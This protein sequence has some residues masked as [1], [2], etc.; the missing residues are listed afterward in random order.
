MSFDSI[1]RTYKKNQAQI[2]THTRIGDKDLGIFGGVYHVGLEKREAFYNAYYDYLF[3]R[4]S[5]PGAQTLKTAEYLTEYQLPDDYTTIT[6]EPANGGIMIDLDFHYD[7]AIQERQ[8]TKEHIDDMICAYTNELKKYYKFAE[9]AAF[10][11][12][13]FEKNTVNCKPPN[14]PHITKDG[15]HL[16][17]GLQ[18]GRAIQNLLR[19]SIM[20]ILSSE[21]FA[22][23]PLKNDW[24]SILDDTITKASTPW[25]IFGSRKPGYEPY[26]LKY[27]YTATYDSY[28]GEFGLECETFTPT[29]IISRELFMRVSARYDAHPRFPLTEE[30]QRLVDKAT[31]EEKRAQSG[32]K[33]TP[34]RRRIILDDIT[35]DSADGTDDLLFTSAETIAVNRIRN[36]EQLDNAIALMLQTFQAS[37]ATCHLP[38]IHEY[39]QILPD[40]F[41]KAGSH[42][43]NRKVAFAL[44]NT[45]NRMFLSWI[46]LRS[47][48]DDF[49]YATIPGLYRDWCQYF[50][51][52]PT[53]GGNG[54]TKKS[55]IYWAK[56]FA[57]EEFARVKSSAI[58][59]YIDATLQH[60]KDHPE[61]DVA[62]V[63][64]QMFKD[65][66]IFIMN[67]KSREW[68]RF[69]NHRWVI[70]PNGS[71]LNMAISNELRAL[72]QERQKFYRNEA[73]LDK[74]TITSST[75]QNETID[76]TEVEK[77]ARNRT[78]FLNSK[79]I[80]AGNLIIKLGKNGYKSGVMQQAELLFLDREFEALADENRYL[81]GF[82]NGVYDYNEKRFRQGKPEDYITQSTKYAYIP[83]DD[84]S[85]HQK[86]MRAEIHEFMSKIFTEKALRDF[87]WEHLASSVIGVNPIVNQTGCFYTGSG[88]NG[89]TKITDLMK[90]T[91]GTYACDNQV[92][93]LMQARGKAESA[94]PQ[95]LKL[96]GKRYANY[97]E[98]Q[99]DDV[100]NDGVFKQIT[101]DKDLNARGLFKGV[102]LEFANQANHVVA[103]NNLMKIKDTTDGTWRRVRVVPY[104]SVFVNPDEYDRKVAEYGADRVFLKDPGLDAKLAIWAP[105]FMTMLIEIVQRTGGRVTDCATVLSASDK[106]RK[107]ED[108]VANY[109][110]TNVIASDNPSFEI[111]KNALWTHFKAWYQNTYTNNRNP[112]TQT[113]L[114]E[115]MNKK[116]GNN[117]T[118]NKSNV[119]WKCVKLRYDDDDDEAGQTHAA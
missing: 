82:T 86:Q 89:K 76:I 94:A 12:F 106:Y 104:T 53:D 100:L 60:E 22:S 58:T 3:K 107:N 39:V 28:D 47:K 7:S 112:I 52:D 70:E 2:K 33:I 77:N 31:A 66:Y 26:R 57:P 37:T 62:Y 95:I 6:G 65:E 23:L 110:G 44:K 8:H 25:Q 35:D 32:G 5:P 115:A 83:Y 74:M 88:G 41:Y 4:A 101:G 51:Q 42:A 118:E 43:M 1:L 72:Y 15:I 92:Q 10:D 84:T 40:D 48:A 67:G 116:Y 14:K 29:S 102:D 98:P 105:Y 17:I 111:K 9:G 87:M 81:I 18:S 46:K 24:D 50:N 113:E 56:Q 96:K 61:Y 79:I 99:K 80:S 91:L 71:S 85:T 11:L 64:Y 27:V 55:I 117:I 90:F 93:L 49:D 36:K 59:T 38:E 69:Q 108:I 97:S 75:D 103:T 114:Y 20:P 78:K 19:K 73:V 63:L 68:Y 109:L 13:V 34:S 16:I 45:D 119:Y 30:A 54:L 21:V